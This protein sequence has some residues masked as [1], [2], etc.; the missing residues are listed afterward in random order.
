LC[1]PNRDGGPG[2]PVP[3]RRTFAA[4]S[5]RRRLTHY[6]RF[7]R[8]LL[9]RSSEN[10][11]ART[12]SC[13]PSPSASGKRPPSA[14]IAL[15][16]SAQNSHDCPSRRH[17]PP[18]ACRSADPAVWAFVAEARTRSTPSTSPNALAR[19]LQSL[20]PADMDRLDP[21]GRWRAVSS[22]ARQMAAPASDADRLHA[23][24]AGVDAIGMDCRFVR[25][26]AKPRASF[27]MF[28]LPID[29]GFSTSL[30]SHL[31]CRRAF[32]PAAVPASHR[33]SPPC[34]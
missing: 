5:A 20:P 17:T 22:G 34:R 15:A 30:L 27:G 6:S 26:D 1:R 8:A 21:T 2:L 28:R 13:R 12:A 29:S 10:A 32:A 11:H 3:S 31:R 24:D 4:G 23:V 18:R 33:E 9:A 14:V 16:R 7:S 25:T 19:Q